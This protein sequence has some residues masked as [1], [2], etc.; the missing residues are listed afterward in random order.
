MTIIPS[1]AAWL[2]ISTELSTRG[3]QRYIIQYR[4]ESPEGFHAWFWAEGRPDVEV[5]THDEG[6]CKAI[7]KYK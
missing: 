7:M 1:L 4:P 5:V 2:P 3:Y 6:V